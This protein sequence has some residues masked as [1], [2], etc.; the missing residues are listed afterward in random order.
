MHKKLFAALARAAQ[1][2]SGKLN[3]QALANTAWAFVPVGLKDELLFAALAVA[4]QL[5]MGEFI[6]QNL[7]NIAWAFAIVDQKDQ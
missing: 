5:R 6:P 3:P 2:H 4:A 1:R 7:A